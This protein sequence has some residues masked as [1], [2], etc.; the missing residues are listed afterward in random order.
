VAIGALRGMEDTKWPSVFAFVS[1]WILGLPLG[2]M[3]SFHWG[4]GPIGIWLGLLIGLIFAASL[5]TWRFHRL[6]RHD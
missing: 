5:M 1:Y 6:T 4:L 2:Y 3:M